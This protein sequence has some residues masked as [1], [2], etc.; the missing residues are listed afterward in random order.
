MNETV[1]KQTKA[2]ENGAIL[3]KLGIFGWGKIEPQVIAG[4][5]LGEPFALI[6]EPGTGKTYLGQIIGEALNLK[7]GYY[8]CSKAEF[9]D[10]IGFP[11]PEAYKAGK[12]EP[13]PTELTIEDKQ[14]IVVDELSRI[15][16]SMSNSWL[17]IL[18]SRMLMG[19]ALPLRVIMGAMN[20]IHHQ[21][22]KPLDEAFA[23]RFVAF[24]PTPS[25]HEMP[26]EIRKE[27]I[28]AETGLDAPSAKYWAGETEGDYRAKYVTSN[29]AFQSASAR[30]R[31][32]IKE[33]AE[34]Y[35]EFSGSPTAQRVTDYVD[36]FATALKKEANVALEGRRLKMLK[37][38]IESTLV[39]KQ[40]LDGVAVTKMP[41]DEL[42]GTVG[43]CV[44]MGL[45]H[46]V[47]GK[48]ELSAHKLQVAHEEASSALKG[49]LS[50]YLLYNT[51]SLSE[52]VALVLKN[53]YDVGM[54]QKVVADVAVDES[55]EADMICLTLTSLMKHRCFL[56]YMPV[57]V[58]QKLVTRISSIPLEVENT[59]KYAPNAD[60]EKVL[61]DKQELDILVKKVTNDPVE[62]MVLAWAYGRNQKEA[63][64]DGDTPST[65]RRILSLYDEAMGELERVKETLLPVKQLYAKKDKAKK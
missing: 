55:V 9:S 6:S 45:P 14:V 20:P 35:M 29:D 3:E 18:G 2:S 64:N 34:N 24:I 7:F 54:V 61:A 51:K 42:I 62:N 19:R 32:V 21:G 23:D 22:T 28:G 36:L 16:R 43:A 17:E 58:V 52:K 48:E 50:E 47:T 31:D 57:D 44:G 37:R 33:S 60:F 59:F 40:A 63:D 38:F 27:I 13:I 26:A 30:L 49:D 41:E 1:N 53:D 4:I 10:I 12:I 8:D 15:N 25:L 39:T 65:I 11:S 5:M 56:D 46:Q